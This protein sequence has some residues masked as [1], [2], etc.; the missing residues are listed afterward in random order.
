[1]VQAGTADAAPTGAPDATTAD[2]ASTAVADAAAVAN[3]V[4][5]D[6]T[7][8]ATIVGPTEAIM[9]SKTDGQSDV[10]LPNAEVSVLQAPE[11][12]TPAGSASGV[13]EASTAR[14]SG[15]QTWFG[16]AGGILGR[17]TVPIKVKK[18]PNSRHRGVTD[19][20]DLT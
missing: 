2:A 20:I 19:T 9:G 10:K 16:K 12:T 17:W 6:T 3:A 4:A 15:S 1:M 11:A 7:K 13:K 8:A 5:T 18:E 14:K